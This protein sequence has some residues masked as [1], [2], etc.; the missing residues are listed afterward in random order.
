MTH[1]A[2]FYDPPWYKRIWQILGFGECHA[3][4]H[5]QHDDFAPGA[6]ITV[7]R[8]HFDMGDRFRILLSGK[9]MVKSRS[10]TN[11]TVD[12][13]RTNTAVSVLPPTAKIRN[14]AQ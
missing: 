1:G 3:P 9:I 12:F 11:V 4:M 13:A 7:T 10:Q 14:F 2:F 5:E 6:L 8:T